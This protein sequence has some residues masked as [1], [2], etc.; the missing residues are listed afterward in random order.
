M[1]HVIVFEHAGSHGAHKYVLRPEP[2]LNAGDGSFF[3]DRI[4]SFIILE[5]NWEF[6]VDAGSVA[7]L[8]PGRYEWA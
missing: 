7:K 4:S 6:L 3:N 2:N 1:P 5:G 8:G